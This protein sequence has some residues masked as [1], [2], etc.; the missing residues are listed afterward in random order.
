MVSGTYI[1]SVVMNRERVEAPDAYPF[2]LPVVRHL[3]KLDFNSRV[4][5]LVG[6]NGTGKST[7]LEAI[8]VNYGFN[9]E[10]GSKNFNFSTYQSHSELSEYITLWKGAAKP[11][12][13]F[14]LRAESFYNVASE[15]DNLGMAGSYGGR[16]LH[17]QSHGESFMS[18][19]LNRFRGGGI[20]ILDEPE[21]ALSPSR[22]LA[23]LARMN[24]LVQDGSQFIIA[25][26]S[27]ILLGYPGADI[28][29]LEEDGAR[30]TPY[31]QTEHYILTKEFLLHPDRMLRE[32]MDE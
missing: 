16:S 11:K 6:E 31:E 5:F 23:M 28:Y 26:H 10:G 22:Q 24:D 13:G 1:R 17:E 21:A 4:T 19:L 32:L 3:E 15:I 25:T 30:L 29:V 9:P 2:C 27:P 18:L 7:L 12:D 20:Y 14:F 8:A